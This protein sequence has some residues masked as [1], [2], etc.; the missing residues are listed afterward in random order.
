MAMIA[1]KQD[2]DSEL[3]ALQQNK[4][5]KDKINSAV[6]DRV[7]VVT[8]DDHVFQPELLLLFLGL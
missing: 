3:E 2:G 1:E 4:R 5:S 7:I 6:Y 8:L